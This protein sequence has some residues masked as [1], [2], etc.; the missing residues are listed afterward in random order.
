M[1]IFDTKKSTQEL[2][3]LGM[4]LHGDKATLETR[5]RGVFS[6]RRSARVASVTAAALVLALVF[7]CFTTACQ[8][9]VR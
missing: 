7:A 4:A 6:R 9:V 1:K 3:G 2:M 8:P 5:I